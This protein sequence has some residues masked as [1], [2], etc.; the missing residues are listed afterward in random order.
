MV[1]I[2][3]IFVAKKKKKK[4]YIQEQTLRVCYMN[5]Y[6]AKRHVCNTFAELLR[7][8][9][10]QLK[11]CNNRQ[12]KEKEETPMSGSRNCLLQSSWDRVTN[13]KTFQINQIG[14]LELQKRPSKQLRQIYAYSDLTRSILSP[15]IPL[16]FRNI[17]SHA[18]LCEMKFT[19]NHFDLI[20]LPVGIIK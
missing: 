17:Q 19:L 18:A 13:R 11:D 5:V 15:Y 2:K 8:L 12:D 4:T 1:A 10:H 6:C 14:H 16:Y 9:T 20:T 7:L 3:K